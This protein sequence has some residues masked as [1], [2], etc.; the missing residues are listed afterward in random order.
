MKPGY[1]TTEFWLQLLAQL[2]GA[3]MASGVLAADTPYAKLV[4]VVLMVLGALGYTYQRGVVKISS[5]KATAM[6]VAAGAVKD[7]S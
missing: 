6:T 3:L 7:P 2:F 4:G 5:D 1:K